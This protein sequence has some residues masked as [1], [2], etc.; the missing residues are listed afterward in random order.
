MSQVSVVVSVFQTIENLGVCSAA[1]DTVYCTE[2][3]LPS[4]RAYVD[5]RSFTYITEVM[6][7]LQ[8]AV[9]DHLLFDYMLFMSSGHVRSRDRDRYLFKLFLWYLS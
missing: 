9:F 1:Y 5:A 8:V 3:R 7:S 2:H 6:I 4:K